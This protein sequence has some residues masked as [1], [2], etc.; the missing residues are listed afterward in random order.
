MAY[1]GWS[2]Y[3]TW[4]VKLWL[5]NDEGL[6]HEANRI[7]RRS[8]HVAQDLEAWIEEMFKENGCKFGDLD[9]IKE[10]AAVDWDEIAAAYEEE[11][12]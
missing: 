8:T 3:E 9:S 12:E 10:F 11:N 1:N 2:N 7:A 5:D 4:N 6:Y